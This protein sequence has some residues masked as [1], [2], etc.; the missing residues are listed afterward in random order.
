MEFNICTLINIIFT[1]QSR[2]DLQRRIQEKDRLLLVFR[3]SC[4]VVQGTVE[5]VRC[6]GADGRS[7]SLY[8]LPGSRAATLPS[9]PCHFGGML[10]D[11]APAFF[12]VH[13]NHRSQDKSNSLSIEILLLIDRVLPCFFGP[14][15][16]IFQR[17]HSEAQLFCGISH[18]LA[19][20][21]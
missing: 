8:C 14:S 21:T 3:D 10:I 1:R 19:S 13:R 6:E 9:H 4:S 11:A 18:G 2:R 20:L 15:F 5:L 16:A 17:S 7:S 12:Q